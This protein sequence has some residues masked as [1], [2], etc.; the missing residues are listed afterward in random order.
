MRSSIH[1]YENI[2]RAGEDVE[3]KESIGSTA[4]KLKSVLSKLEDELKGSGPPSCT[5]ERI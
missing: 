4:Q 1:Y 2:A 3:R 5:T